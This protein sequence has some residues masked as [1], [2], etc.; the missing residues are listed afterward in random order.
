[1]ILEVIFFV[2]VKDIF[3][4]FY[5]YLLLGRRVSFYFIFAKPFLFI[6]E[7]CW[8]L[9]NVHSK[10][11][12]GTLR[13]FCFIVWLCYT[14][15][16]AAFL[17]VKQYHIP[18]I[19]KLRHHLFYIF[20]HLFFSSLFGIFTF[21]FMNKVGLELIFLELSF[22]LEALTSPTLFSVFLFLWKNF[23]RLSL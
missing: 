12:R 3:G 21:T 22:L 14:L 19:N 23:K 17:M 9:L 20:L 5:R 7:A 6:T 11:I 10:Y 8:V 1:M 15:L 13:F 2:S 18:R 4:D 16:K